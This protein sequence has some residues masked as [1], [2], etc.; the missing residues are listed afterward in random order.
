MQEIVEHGE[1]SP[2]VTIKL[3]TK[4]WIKKSDLMSGKLVMTLQI[5][6]EIEVKCNPFIELLAE[7][8]AEFKMNAIFDFIN[9]KTFE[10]IQDI[11]T[12]KTKEER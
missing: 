9:K 5:G 2:W 4:D 7:P 11:Q 3:T 6:Q 8:D 1:D 12:L 10:L